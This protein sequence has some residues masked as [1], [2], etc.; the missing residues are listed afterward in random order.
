MFCDEHG[1]PGGHCRL[2]D[3]CPMRKACGQLVIEKFGRIGVDMR[4]PALESRPVWP[5]ASVDEV[6]TWT[7]GTRADGEFGGHLAGPDEQDWN[8]PEDA[9]YDEPRLRA[10]DRAGPYAARLPPFNPRTE[11]RHRCKVYRFGASWHWKCCEVRCRG[12]KAGSLTAA[13]GRALEHCEAQGE[14]D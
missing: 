12:G 10:G 5:A 11:I 4:Y 3:R 6:V 14:E 1:T 9:V 7:G 13:Y 8:S 2:D